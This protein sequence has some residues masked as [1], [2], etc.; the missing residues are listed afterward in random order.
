[1]V[2]SQQL[3][4]GTNFVRHASHPNTTALAPFVAQLPEDQIGLV[5]WKH[6]LLGLGATRLKRELGLKSRQERLYAR[7]I[8]PWAAWGAACRV[9][10]GWRRC[11]RSRG[12]ERRLHFLPRRR[13]NIS[14]VSYVG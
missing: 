10:G 7:A 12:L 14:D 8:L 1:M 11:Q 9:S 5:A 2:T 6:A 3:N 13:C 4:L